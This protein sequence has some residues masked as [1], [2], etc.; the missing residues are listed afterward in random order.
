MKKLIFAIV[1][2]VS[3]CLVK[4]QVGQGLFVG[5][6][7]GYSSS[8]SKTTN[9]S[10]S[11]E[12]SRTSTFEITPRIGYFFTDNFGAGLNIGYSNIVTPDESDPD[13]KLINNAISFGLFGRYALPLGDESKFAFTGDLNIGYSSITGK[14][15]VGSISESAD[16][17]GILSFNIMPG[18]L[19]FPTPKIGIEAGLGNILGVN[20][21]TQ[22]SLDNNDFKRVTTSLEVFNIRSLNLNFGL[23]YY[24]NRS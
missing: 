18:I 7:L 24:F 9:G 19:F 17:I 14:Y 16:P 10:S 21:A 8:K 23:N 6:G 12:G 4:A 1:L 3:P 5:G 2:F 11:F 15:V 20:V 22:R 13:V